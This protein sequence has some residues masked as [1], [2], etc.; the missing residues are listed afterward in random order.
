MNSDLKQLIRLQSID[1]CIQKIRSRIEQFPAQSKALDE[2]L[3][4]STAALEAVRERTKQNQI[5]RKKAEGE[6]GTFESKIS[7]YREQMMAVKTNEEY[8][9]MQ[10]EIEFTQSSVRTVEDGILNLMME[11]ETLQAATKTAD[12]H[13]KEDQ[14][15]VQEE[16]KKLEQVH[17]QDVSALESYLTE[18]AGIEK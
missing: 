8:K 15:L 11:A 5:E 2:T 16:R 13:L 18:R 14:R 9:A 7:K 4:S 12:A 1:L 6:V 10:K 3:K 17:Q